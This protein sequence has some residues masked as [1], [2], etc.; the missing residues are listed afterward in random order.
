M[1]TYPTLTSVIIPKNSNSDIYLYFDNALEINNSVPISSFQINFGKYTINSSKFQGNSILILSVS[2]EIKFGDD[3]FISYTPPTDLTKTLRGCVQDQNNNVQL[4]KASVRQFSNVEAINLKESNDSI[5]IDPATNVAGDGGTNL[6]NYPFFNRANPKDPSP[7]DF[8]L[9][10]GER[11]AIQ[12]SNIDDAS[13]KVPNLGRIWMA[14]NDAC[15]YIDSYIKAANN[16]CTL[17]ISSNRRRTACIIA[18]YYLDTVRRRKDVLEDYERCLKEMSDAC[19][20]FKGETPPG[21]PLAIERGGIMRV[22]RIPQFVNSVSGKGLSS[23]WTDSAADLERD[24]R[25]QGASYSAEVNND[26][27]DNFGSFG[28][29]ESAPRFDLEAPRDDGD[30]TTNNNP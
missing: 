17:I 10:Y 28:A 18:R 24:F 25:T 22:W 12:I 16:S 11:E 26:D 1:S 6:S 2:P 13:A 19:D 23:F 15:A 9:M 4:K 14:L 29:P 30:I 8:I 21:K 27:Y 3:I 20:S 7:Q 5:Q